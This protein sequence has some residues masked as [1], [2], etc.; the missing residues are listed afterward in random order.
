[1][2]DY[3]KILAECFAADNALLT[4][5]H[6]VSGMG[7]ESCVE[8]TFADLQDAGVIFFKILDGDK[9]VGYFGKEVYGEKQYLTGFFLMPQFRNEGSRGNFWNL[10]ESH[11]NIPFFCGLYEK[12]I[13]AN[14]FIQSQGGRP[15]RR[16]ALSDGEAVLY[17]IG[18]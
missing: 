16:V 1:M 3:K 2:E 6:V 13:P 7:L 8:K 10:I 14:K 11:F 9:L 18:A 4:K 12:N 15:V 5:W 17:K